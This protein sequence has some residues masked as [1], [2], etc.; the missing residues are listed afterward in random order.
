MKQTYFSYFF[1][2]FKIKTT[3]MHEHV[4]NNQEYVKNTQEH[5]KTFKHIQE[6]L[7]NYYHTLILNS[8]HD[9]TKNKL[10]KEIIPS[11]NI[12]TVVDETFGRGP[13]D[14]GKEELGEGE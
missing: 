2:G 4:M 11:C 7:N 6:N 1:Y 10:G 5:L 3:D 8:H 12:H 13:K 14:G 9:N